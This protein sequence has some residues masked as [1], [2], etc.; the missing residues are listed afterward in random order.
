MKNGN[1]IFSRKYS[2][3]FTP[4]FR[5]PSVRPVPRAQPPCDHGPITSMFGTPGFFAST[6]R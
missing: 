4:K 5:L 1:W 2:D 3:V 6:E